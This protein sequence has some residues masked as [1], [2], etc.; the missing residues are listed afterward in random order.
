[1]SIRPN[2]TDADVPS[3]CAVQI[4]AAQPLGGTATAAERMCHVGNCYSQSRRLR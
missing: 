1:M 4:Q 3:Q 2:C